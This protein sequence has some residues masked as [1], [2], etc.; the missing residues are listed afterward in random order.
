MILPSSPKA[1][2]PYSTNKS[3]LTDVNALFG[4]DVVGIV[5]QQGS[6]FQ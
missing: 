2:Y 5:R 1:P 6:R 4:G 3:T